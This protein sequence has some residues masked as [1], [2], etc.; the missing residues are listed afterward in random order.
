[1]ARVRSVLLRETDCLV[2]CTHTNRVGMHAWPALWHNDC[3]SNNNKIG[4]RLISCMHQRAAQL[5]AKLRHKGLAEN[6]RNAADT[7]EHEDGGAASAS[8][9]I[10]HTAATDMVHCKVWYGMVEVC[11]GAHVAVSG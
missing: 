9:F 1:M 6:S 7:P 4:R 2:T 3:M 10:G 5:S 8:E 11:E